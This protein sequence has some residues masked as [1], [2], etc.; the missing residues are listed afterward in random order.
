M[1]K[2]T[3]I[4]NGLFCQLQKENFCNLTDFLPTKSL[5]KTPF[6]H[7]NPTQH[8]KIYIWHRSVCRE[9]SIL[10]PSPHKK[11]QQKKCSPNLIKSVA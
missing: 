11:Q 7:F 8:G 5:D 10:L 9:K 6:L 2:R 4:L 1:I 3:N